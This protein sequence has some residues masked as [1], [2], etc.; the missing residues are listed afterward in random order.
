MLDIVNGLLLERGRVLLAHRSKS[1][2]S[3]PDTWSFPG[4]HVEDGETLE[5][6]LVRELAEEVGV[7]PTSWR[8]LDS[9]HF[10]RGKA[11]FHFFAI[12]QWE[13]EPV[14]LG[15]EH[16]ELRWVGLDDAHEMPGLTFPI[17]TD[18]FRALLQSKSQSQTEEP[19]LGAVRSIR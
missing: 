2:S 17:Y 1:R 18:I 15:P 14:N 7:V 16:S 9:F 3:Y 4:G 6:A 10:N 11:T 12:D 13:Q 5:D 8:L 19:E